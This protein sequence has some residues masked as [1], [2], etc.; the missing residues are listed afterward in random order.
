MTTRARA[1]HS[2]SRRLRRDPRATERAKRRSEH[3]TVDV[4]VSDVDMPSLNGFALVEAIR[5]SN[6]LRDLPLS[7]LR[8]E[9]GADRAHGLDA[10]ADAH[11]QPAARALIDHRELV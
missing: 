3:E 7:W 6:R 4:V 10:G 5:A 9:R 2:R 8:D 1:E 11:P